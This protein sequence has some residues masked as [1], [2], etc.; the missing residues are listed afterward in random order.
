MLHINL[1]STLILFNIGTVSSCKFFHQNKK[2]YQL[3]NSVQT[4]NMTVWLL[5]WFQEPH[6]NEGEI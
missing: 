5:E 4:S 6:V 1:H 2:M 3:G